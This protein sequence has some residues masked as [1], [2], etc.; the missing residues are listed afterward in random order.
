MSQAPP[1]DPSQ[2]RTPTSSG[3]SEEFSW[4]VQ[5]Q[6]R[7]LDRI[8]DWIR[9]ADSKT[10]P[11]LAID[12]AMIATIVALAA[13]PGVW[14]QWSGVWI[15]LGTSFLL[16]SLLMVA[17][18]T[19]PQLTPLRPSLVFFGDIAALSPNEYSTRIAARSPSAYLDDLI[20]QCHRNSE[21]AIRRYRWMR[22]ATLALLVGMVPWLASLF[23]IVQG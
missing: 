7:A 23:L 16:A 18:A 21:I 17:F 10:S 1:R 19:S 13:R 15:G 5:T 14:T 9:A 4:I 11:I 3:A 12:T 2:S 20:A 22:Y 8:S 6:E